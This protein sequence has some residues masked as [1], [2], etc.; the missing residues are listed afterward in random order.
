[1]SPAAFDDELLKNVYDE[2]LTES[3]VQ[4]MYHT[5]LKKVISEGEAIKEI[6]VFSKSGL[7]KFRAKVFIDCS[8]DA[9]LA[10]GAN[11]PFSVG[12]PEDGLTQAMTV[13]FRMANVDKEEMLK[14]RHIRAA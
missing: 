12:R 3:G 5:Y 13:S 4:I 1:L 9:D 11:V 14:T 2:L 6:E 10:A 8:G 7:Q